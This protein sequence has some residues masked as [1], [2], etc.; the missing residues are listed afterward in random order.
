MNKNNS[1]DNPDLPSGLS[2]P[3]RHALA[4]A[5][6]TRLEQIAQVS[7]V[8][9]FKLHGMGPKGVQTIRQALR[10]KGLAFKGPEN[11][12]RISLQANQHITR[13]EPKKPSEA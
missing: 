5:G 1:P 10:E 6:I 13:R 3:A 2:N 9:L 7:E 8:E 12:A 4:A 11:S